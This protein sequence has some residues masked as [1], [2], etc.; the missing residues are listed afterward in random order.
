MTAS[1]QDVI[2]AFGSPS[3]PTAITQKPFDYNSSHYGRLLRPNAK[4]DPVDLYCYA[5][6]LMYQDGQ[7]D[8]FLVLLPKCLSAW[9]ENLMTSHESDSAGFVEQVSAALSKHTGFR[10]LL[11]PKGYTAVSEFMLLAILDKIE[12]QW[13]NCSS[14]GRLCAVLQYA[15]VLMYPDEKNPIFSPWTNDAGGGAPVPWETDGH[16][17]DQSWLP[18]N[19]HF[20]RATLNPGYV[21][22]R[23]S[24]SNSS[25]IVSTRSNNASHSRIFLRALMRGSAWVKNM[26]EGNTRRRLRTLK[27]R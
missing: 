25:S 3:T 19:V 5:E 9:Q 21:G 4:P 8:L 17:F 18:E 11:S 15:S 6:N 10:D 1:V 14:T 7:R 20:L 27:K 23:V 16:I 24:A 2:R 22:E 12:Q 26:S 13:W